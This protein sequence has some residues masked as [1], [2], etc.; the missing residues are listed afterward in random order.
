[1]KKILLT[2]S[3]FSMLVNATENTQN[4]VENK[5][6]SKELVCIDPGH[7]LRGNSGLEEIAPGSSKKKAKVSS[8]TR[9]VATKKY[10]Y[11]LT[12]EIGLKIKEKLEKKGYNTFMTRE[13][14]NVNIS[15]KERSLMTNKK[16]CSVYI[17]LHADGIDNKSING[18]SVL[19]SS[20]KN[21]YTKK[22]QKESEKFSKILLEE[23]IKST[24]AKNRGISYRDD[25]TGTNWSMVVNTLI[26]MG[27]MSN[28]IEDKKMSTSEYQNK[29]VD[30]IVNGIERYIKEK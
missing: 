25:L 27:F 26:E 13:T 10:E 22:V 6:N 19:T 1:M 24:G 30:G 29:M 21:I 14:H 17:R 20:S 3:L 5:N 15:N 4:K 2:I 28:D 8:G 11:E 12:L 16:G 9:G 7:Q 23:Y 18:A